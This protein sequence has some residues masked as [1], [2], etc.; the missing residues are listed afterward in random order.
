MVLPIL[1]GVAS[2][3]YRF[4]RFFG[5]LAE[6]MDRLSSRLVSQIRLQFGDRIHPD[7]L[8]AYRPRIPLR[9]Y[10]FEASSACRQVCICPIIDVD[11]VKSGSLPGR[12]SQ[13]REVLSILDIDYISLPCPCESFV[14]ET[15][16]KYGRWRLEAEAKGGKAQFP[17]LV[18][19][20]SETVLYTN[21]IV[22]YL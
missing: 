10:E 5:V 7:A 13:V 2:R 6:P 3:W 4:Y 9:L 15:A 21:E 16:A 19:P 12:V 14:D 22:P 1:M 20:N 18:D 11:D 17:F 8:S